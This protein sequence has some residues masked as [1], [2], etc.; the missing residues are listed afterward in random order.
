MREIEAALPAIPT[1]HDLWLGD[2]RELDLAWH[3]QLHHLSFGQGCGFR[4][5]EETAI[6]GDD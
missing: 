2:A 4:A 5:D 3:P 1:T 6:C